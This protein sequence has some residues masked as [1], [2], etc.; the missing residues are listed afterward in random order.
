[1]RLLGIGDNVL[2]HYVDTGVKYPGGNAVNVTVFAARQGASDCA[3][4]GVVGDDA[5]GDHLLES[6]AAE[7][8]DLSLVRR[9]VGPNGIAM[10]SIADDGD[11]VFVGSNKGGVQHALR[12]RLTETDMTFAA[13][14]DVVHSS[15]YS[16]MEQY[17]P[18]LADVTK[19]S[20]DF[21]HRA[22]AAYLAETCPSV[23]HAF[24]SGSDLDSAA[25]ESLCDS[26][27]G[28]GCD[29]VV[30]TRGGAGAWVATQGESFAMPAENASVVD[31]L[32]AGDAFIGGFLVDLYENTEQGRSRIS[33]VRSAAQRG[34]HTAAEACMENGAFGR[35]FVG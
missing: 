24:F 15:V 28:Y 14:A 11:R 16:S 1:M 23:T 17:L 10:V 9:A 18:Q 8:L 3:Y 20:F 21:S 30:V 5:E 35:G 19:V 4:I 7:G 27:L 31:T 6:L 22:D 29:S 26:V 34:A 32:G 25:V 33:G 2:D 13:R 12:L